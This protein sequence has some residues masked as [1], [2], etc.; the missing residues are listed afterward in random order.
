M[1]RNALIVTACFAIACARP[2]SEP[3][4]KELA[5]FEPPAS[6]DHPETC[7]DPYIGRV[8]GADEAPVVV[9]KVPP[10]VTGDQPKGFAV[11]EAI[12]D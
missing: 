11:V 7:P 8:G 1:V 6:A 12:V 4:R 9:R 3:S 2:A 5:T 10:V